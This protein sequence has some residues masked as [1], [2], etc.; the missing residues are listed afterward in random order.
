MLGGTEMTRIAIISATLCMLP[1]STIALMLMLLATGL[2]G[3][4]KYARTR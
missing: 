1:V 3:A 4:A 2:Y